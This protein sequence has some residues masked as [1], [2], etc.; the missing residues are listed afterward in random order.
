[1]WRCNTGCPV[2]TRCLQTI[3]KA[4]VNAGGDAHKIFRDFGIQVKGV[5]ELMSHNVV[6]AETIRR[7]RSLA[8]RLLSL[9]RNGY[10]PVVIPVK[11]VPVVFVRW[12]CHGRY[13]AVTP[14]E[15]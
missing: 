14:E 7:S 15:S 9:S 2:D 13:A 4:G 1:M 11:R 8:S 6:Q 3:L 12:M 10:S 5:T